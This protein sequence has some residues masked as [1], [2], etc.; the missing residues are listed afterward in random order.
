MA[1]DRALAWQSI[2]IKKLRGILGARGVNQPDHG[3]H[4]RSS[5]GKREW[6]PALEAEFAEYVLPAW[7]STRLDN[8]TEEPGCISRAHRERLDDRCPF[9]HTV[10]LH[11]VTVLL[12]SAGY[13]DGVAI[14]Q[15][16]IDNPQSIYA[17][18]VRNLIEPVDHWQDTSVHYQTVGNIGTKALLTEERILL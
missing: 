10:L 12:G 7:E 2:A 5:Q 17:E 9:D 16:S 13:D 11:C 18:V 6:S 1:L 3:K 14:V 15:R 4:Q 8:L